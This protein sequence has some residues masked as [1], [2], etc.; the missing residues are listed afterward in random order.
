MKKFVFAL[1]LTFALP[2][3]A[4]AAPTG[5]KPADQ[6]TVPP[7]HGVWN[8][9]DTQLIGCITDEAWQAAQAAAAAAN[10]QHLPVVAAGTVVSD[11]YGMTYQC[12]AFVFQGCY[13]LTHTSAYIADMQAIAREYV[14]N[15]WLHTGTGLDGWI[16]SV[17]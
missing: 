10:G 14:A 17:Q 1:V 16:A 8:S 13:D 12:P 15:G 11:Q 6:C 7:D 5:W 2:L 3:S 9:D 4:F